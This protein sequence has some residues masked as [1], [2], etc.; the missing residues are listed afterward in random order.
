L[1]FGATELWPPI[2]SRPKSRPLN[3]AFNK[4]LGTPV[5]L[6]GLLN[7]MKAAL[8]M[9]DPRENAKGLTPD[10]VA[11]IEKVFL[12]YVIGSIT[13]R[14]GNKFS[15]LVVKINLLDGNGKLVGSTSAAIQNF[16]PNQVWNFEA[17]ILNDEI[18]SA[19]VREIMG[20]L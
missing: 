1:V 18:S 11:I 7:K 17:G 19:A 5:Q 13:N 8:E 6:T 9:S 12:R 20:W 16:E 14:S 4:A 2:A 15:Y 3:P 10:D